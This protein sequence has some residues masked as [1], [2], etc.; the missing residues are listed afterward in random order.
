M[1][2]LFALCSG[3]H[4]SQASS[5]AALLSTDQLSTICASERQRSQAHCFRKPL[6]RLFLLYHGFLILL[7]QDFSPLSLQVRFM[8]LAEFFPCHV[9]FWTVLLLVLVFLLLRSRAWL[10]SFF[11]MRAM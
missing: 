3:T 4:H 11:V 7:N 9:N 8:S 10:S 2:V 5:Q 6:L 1:L